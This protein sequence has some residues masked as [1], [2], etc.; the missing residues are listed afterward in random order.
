MLGSSDFSLY[1]CNRYRKKLRKVKHKQEMEI[2]RNFRTRGEHMAWV[3]QQ[4]GWGPL[5]AEDKAAL[6]DA[7]R[8][9]TNLPNA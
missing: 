9:V 3:A 4:K 5:S 1:L 8:M 2:V 6:D 7:V